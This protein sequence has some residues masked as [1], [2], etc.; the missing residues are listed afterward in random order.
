MRTSVLVDLHRAEHEQN[1][2]IETHVE[3]CHVFAHVFLVGVRCFGE[4][5]LVTRR[6]HA[7]DENQ[8]DED[9]G[10]GQAEHAAIEVRVFEMIEVKVA[11]AQ[12]DEKAHGDHHADDAETRVQV[13]IADDD[14]LEQVD[15]E[16]QQ[17]RVEPNETQ[18]V[19]F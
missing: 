4:R 14:E 8:D 10:K 5:F 17:D 9:D 11:Y 18:V 1:D 19:S 16:Y 15:G 6:P 7:G 13:R 3:T 2:L 12:S